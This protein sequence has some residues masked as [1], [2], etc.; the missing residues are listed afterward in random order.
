M[1]AFLRWPKHIPAG[2]VVNGIVSHQDMLP[3]LLA[4]VGEPDIC[5]KL[6]AGH[7]I[8]TMTYNV[9]IDGLNMLPYLTGK[10]KESPRTSFVYMS[11]DGEVIAIRIG[12]YKCVLSEQRA[13]RMQCWAEPFVKLR[14]PKLFNLRRDPFERADDNSNT[15]WDWLLSHAF[16]IYGMQEVIASMIPSFVAHPPR[17]TPASFNLDGVMKDLQSSSGGANH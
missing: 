12:D 2:S 10:V 5:A 7:K 15:Y 11:D 4:A 3:T 9:H 17:Q 1:P 16:V 8:G 13:T 14:M 6:E